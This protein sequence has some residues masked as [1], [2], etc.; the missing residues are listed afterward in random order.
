MPVYNGRG[1]LS[2]AFNADVD[3]SRESPA[4]AILELLLARGAVV[5]YSDPHVPSLPRMRHH[6]GLRMDSTPLTPEWL[7]SLDVALIVTDHAWPAELEETRNLWAS[8]IS[9]L[10]RVLGA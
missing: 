3:D 5:S 9:S 2:G 6:A 7:R 10:L 1:E 8:Q 4:L